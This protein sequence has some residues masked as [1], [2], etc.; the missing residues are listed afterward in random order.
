MIG[1]SFISRENSNE[2]SPWEE[3]KRRLL[4]LEILYSIVVNNEVEESRGRLAR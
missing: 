4:Q 2:N 3:K 1:K